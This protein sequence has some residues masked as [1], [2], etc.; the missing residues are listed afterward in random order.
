MRDWQEVDKECLRRQD[1]VHVLLSARQDSIEHLVD[2]ARVEEP[3]GCFGNIQVHRREIDI[4]AEKLARLRKELLEERIVKHSPRDTEVPYAQDT[5]AALLQQRGPKVS[6]FEP[7]LISRIYW[8]LAS[9]LI[10][11]DNPGRTDS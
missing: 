4:V 11:A 1:R 8:L 9:S 3:L 5:V 10:E 6:P 7:Y 2:V